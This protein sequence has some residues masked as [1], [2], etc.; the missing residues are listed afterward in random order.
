MNKIT[1]DKIFVCIHDIK[2]ATNK[3]K[4]HYDINTLS[5]KEQS[6]GFW[7]ANSHKEGN[8]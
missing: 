3:M 5:I 8:V 2:I 1:Y 7:S 6:L 4:L